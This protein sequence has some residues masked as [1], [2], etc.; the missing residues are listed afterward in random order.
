MKIKTLGDTFFYLF[1]TRQR[2]EIVSLVFRFPLLNLSTVYAFNNSRLCR[3]R[4]SSW[5]FYVCT[6]GNAAVAAKSNYSRRRSTSIAT[7]PTSEIAS[8]RRERTVDGNIAAWTR[9]RFARFHVTARWKYILYLNSCGVSLRVL[10][11]RCTIVP[12]SKLHVD[13]VK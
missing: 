11:F 8:F 5:I 1:F 10:H 2:R 4:D 13:L 3:T 9:K 12:R 7:S 6:A